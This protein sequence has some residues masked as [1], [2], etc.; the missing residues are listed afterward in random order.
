MWVKEWYSETFKYTF[1][2]NKEMPG[3]NTYKL[4]GA[5]WLSGKVLDSRPKGHRFEPYPRH[6]D[7]SLSKDTY[8]IA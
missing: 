5:Q 4:V 8:I 1:L 6:C 3:E 7:V 2:E